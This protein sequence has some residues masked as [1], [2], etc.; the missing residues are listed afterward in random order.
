[1]ILSEKLDNL[2]CWWFVF[3]NN[4]LHFLR[5]KIIFLSANCESFLFTDIDSTAQCLKTGAGR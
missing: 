1:M 3:F 4:Q 5:L 2:V